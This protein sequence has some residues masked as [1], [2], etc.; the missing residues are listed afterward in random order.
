MVMKLMLESCKSMY[1]TVFPII[2]FIT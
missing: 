2:V 1:H